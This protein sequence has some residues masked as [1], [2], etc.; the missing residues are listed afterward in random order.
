MDIG[1]VL[2]RANVTTTRKAASTRDVDSEYVL[3]PYTDARAH[4]EFGGVTIV[5]GEG[6]Y[7]YDEYGKKYIEGLSG[8]WNVALGYGES[9][10]VEA[11]TKQMADLPYYHTF[12]H[13]ANKPSALLAEKLVSIAPD[14]LRH[15]FF[16]NSGSEA[17]DS[18]IKMIWFYNNAAGRPDKKKIIGRVKG[19]HGITI[20][21]GSLTGIERNHK[22]FDLPIE[23]FLHTACPHY[24]RY[25]EAFESEEEFASRLAGELEELILREGPETVAAFF[26]EPVMGA[27]GVIVPPRTY[28]EKV[29]RVCEKYDVLLV[30]DEVIT[31]FGR[32][33]AMFGCG[34]FGI[35]PDIMVVSKQITSAYMPL[36]AV[37]LKD[38][39]FSAIARES[40]RLGT[41][42][43]GF[44]TSG[45]PVS[46]AV[47][48]EN[49]DIIETEKLVGRARVAGEVLASELRAME[50]SPIV[51][52]V[53][54][55]GLLAGIELVGDK[56]TKEPLG[57]PGVAGNDF[58]SYAEEVGLIV[59]SIGDTVALCPPLIIRDD[60]IKE[61][62]RRF[63]A[64]LREVEKR[65]RAGRYS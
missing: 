26:G 57:R 49:I 30:A 3:H 51:G 23:R 41:F 10:L 32:T 13:K 16:A 22:S 33:G 44:T 6:I 47:A 21:A 48:L 58:A 64:A 31:G 7:V 52:E 15:V 4:Q 35:R 2:R 37:M 29:Q 20:G 27:G 1:Q 45:H 42:G 8:L 46:A 18:A 25:G 60:E 43:H 40:A 54:Q 24:Y 34:T 17:N 36:S 39:I 12:S 50:S 11:A 59:R 63:G 56:E 61:L 5:K 55:V 14:G 62:A 38:E 53:R 28:W 9:R 65:S 19:Y